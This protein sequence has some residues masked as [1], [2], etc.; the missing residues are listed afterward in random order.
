MK[1]VHFHK[2]A[3]RFVSVFF[4]H[5]VD[6]YCSLGYPTVLP[7]TLFGNAWLLLTKKTQ[8]TSPQLCLR[9]QMHDFIYFTPS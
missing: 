2:L 5:A 7:F 3:A 4:P 9:W 6:A 8:N 1:T